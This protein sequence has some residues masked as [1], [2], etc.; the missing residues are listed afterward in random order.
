MDLIIFSFIT[1]YSILLTLD[2]QLPLVFPDLGQPGGLR[3]AQEDRLSVPHLGHQHDRAHD[4]AAV[5]GGLGKVG[6]LD[7]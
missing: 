5:R 7:L 2:W 4:G 1:Q 3:P 6:G